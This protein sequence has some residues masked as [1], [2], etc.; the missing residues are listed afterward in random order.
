MTE[1]N[2]DVR[3]AKL[4]RDQKREREREKGRDLES[5]N[6][7]TDSL[8]GDQGQ[9]GNLHESAAETQRTPQRMSNLMIWSTKLGWISPNE[10][11]FDLAER[12]TSAHL[13]FFACHRSLI[14]WITFFIFPFCSPLK[15]W[16][17]LKG[18][19]YVT[20]KGFQYEVKKCHHQEDAPCRWKQRRT[21]G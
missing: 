13:C 4:E 18:A 12:M 15:G 16:E 14:S 21:L 5:L 10:A 17:T 8:C 6:S 3:Q 19:T 7:V 1:S 11:L 20:W 2:N 9:I